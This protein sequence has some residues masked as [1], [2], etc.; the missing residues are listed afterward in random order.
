[1]GR[2]ARNLRLSC[3][4]GKPH[5]GDCNDTVIFVC[6]NDG[7]APTRLFR[8]VQL[9][10]TCPSRETDRRSSGHPPHMEYVPR[11]AGQSSS[12]TPPFEG[13][14]KRPW[15]GID[16][17]TSYACVGVWQNNRVEIIPN[18]EGNRT[19]PSYVAFTDTDTF[20]GDV[21]KHHAAVNPA[22]TVFGA[23]RLVGRQFDYPQ[24]IADRTYW[25]FSVVEGSEGQ[26]LIEVT[27]RG[28]K[29]RFAAEEILSMVLSKMVG[30]AE[31]YLGEEVGKLIYCSLGPI[32]TAEGIPW[33]LGVLK[34]SPACPMLP[35]CGH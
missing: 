12:V 8:L 27:I 18:E 13:N 4:V 11:A 9:V 20:I 34:Q 22:N 17:G 19:T 7:A 14:A 6:T 35:S 24:V 1:M 33:C 31:A 15:I 28:E 10:A 26:P 30:L 21:A 29:E 2:T 5:P 32:Q 3:R 25:P 16:L 23:M